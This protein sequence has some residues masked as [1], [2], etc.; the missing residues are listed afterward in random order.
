MS[1]AGPVH[2]RGWFDD[3][4]GFDVRDLT[5]EATDADLLAAA[6]ENPHAFAV[7]YDRYAEGLY[8]YARRR[9]GPDVAPD[10]VANTFLAAF[11]ARNRYDPR[12]AA[13]RTWLYS[14][15]SKELASHYRAESARYRMYARLRADPAGED[16]AE[17]VGAVVTATAVRAALAVALA[18]PGWA[19][20]WR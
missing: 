17:R 15:L 7:L 3:D 19:G 9:V 20:G 12:R 5:A 8:T 13:A 18:G 1:L 2:R 16:I 6:G 4:H 14:I 10:L 11:R